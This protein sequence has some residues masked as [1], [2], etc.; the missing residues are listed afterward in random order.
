M[1]REVCVC[2]REAYVQA[3]S[4]HV[5]HATVRRASLAQAPHHHARF[6]TLCVCVFVCVCVCVCVCVACYL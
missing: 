4:M 6:P 2:V 5:E 1:R 3:R